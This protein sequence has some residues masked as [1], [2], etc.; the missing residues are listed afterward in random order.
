MPLLISMKVASAIPVSTFCWRTLSPFFTKTTR[1]SCSRSWRSFCF[2]WVWFVTSALL[3]PPSRALCC[4]VIFSRSSG[5]SLL[6][7]RRA[8][9]LWMGTTTA[10]ATVAVSMSA[11]VLMPGRRCSERSGMR[12]FT[13]KFVTSSWLPA[14]FVVA[15]LAIS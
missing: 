8:V 15:V 5:D 13:S 14:F 9:T 12:I 1:C 2:S 11:V 7:A 3:S 6:P 10:F 4:A